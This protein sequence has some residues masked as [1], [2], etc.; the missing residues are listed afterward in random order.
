MGD[1]NYISNQ[2]IGGQMLDAFNPLSSLLESI[3]NQA[4]APLRAEI[5]SLRK[6]LEQNRQSNQ[7]EMLVPEGCLNWETAKTRSFLSIKQTAYLLN[8]SEKSVR[9]KIECGIIKTSKALRHHRIP[10]GEIEMYQQRT[11]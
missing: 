2:M 9:R 1:I 10:I 4:L 11:V 6:Q 3:V 7:K 5:D 8:M